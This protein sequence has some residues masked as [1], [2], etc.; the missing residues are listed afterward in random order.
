MVRCL[1]RSF[2]TTAVALQVAEKQDKRFQVEGMR[3][4]KSQS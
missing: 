4:R 3:G 2:A 1:T